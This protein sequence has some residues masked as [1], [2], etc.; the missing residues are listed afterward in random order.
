M[1]LKRQEIPKNWPVFRKGTKY[2][3]RPNS[4][5]SSGIPLL[6]LIRDMMGIA[7][8]KK[9]VKRSIHLKNILLNT[10][11]VTDEKNG[12]LLFDVVTLVPSKKNY[13]LSL[14]ES[15][16]LEMQEIKSSEAEKK[17]SKVRNKKVLKG[18]KI[19]INLSDGSNFLSDMKCNTGDSVIVNL[20][21][22][23]LEKCIPLAEKANA[24]VFAGKHAGKV[25]TIKKIDEVHQM[26]ELDVKGNPISVL[27]KQ[28]MV[29]E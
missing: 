7:Q 11:P 2:I 16:K 25:G 18:K 14:T 23:K 8:N 15:G 21:D 12:V 6:V 9:E 1:H 19:Q 17:V 28:V 5:L 10:K 24:Q 20:K 26:V 22:R 27:I 3:A 29:I 13:R 4:N